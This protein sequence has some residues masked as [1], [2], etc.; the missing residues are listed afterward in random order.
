MP[1]Y[2]V[3]LGHVT[4][5]IASVEKQYPMALASQ[6]HCRCCTRATGANHNRVV[7]ITSGSSANCRDEMLAEN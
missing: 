3:S 7:H 6:Q 2:E 1:V 4:Q 5:K